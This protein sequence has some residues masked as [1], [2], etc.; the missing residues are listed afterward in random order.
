MFH[1]PDTFHIISFEILR[2]RFLSAKNAMKWYIKSLEKVSRFNKLG[3]S[4]I[5][6][7]QVAPNQKFVDLLCKQTPIIFVIF[8]KRWDIKLHLFSTYSSFVYSFSIAYSG[9]IVEVM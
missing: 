5:N 3:K 2:L 4:R 6:L 7:N 1:L 8:G 9:L